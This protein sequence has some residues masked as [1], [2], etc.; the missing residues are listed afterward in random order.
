MG[1]TGENVAERWSVS[2]EDQDAFALR[3]Q[4]RWA[5]A[6]G[7]GRFADELVSVG[8][9]ERDE[10]P[11]PGTSLETLVRAAGRWMMLIRRWQPE[12]LLG[13]AR[14]ALEERMLDRELIEHLAD[15]VSE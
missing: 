12:A 9:L 5:E 4:Q 3:S 8:G 10:H 1:E 11:R 15:G 14:P 7:E 6:Q 13:R 2:R